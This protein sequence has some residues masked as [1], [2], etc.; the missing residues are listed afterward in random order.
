MWRALRSKNK[1]KFLDG[2]IPKSVENQPLFEAWDRCNN[3]LLSWL[4]LSLSPEIAKSVMW[5]SNASDM[6]ND[7]KN[8]YSQGDVFRVGELKEEF[9][10]I[11]QGDL[12]ITSYF[13]KLKSVWE[14]LENLHTIPSCIAC[15][16]GYNCGLKIIRDYA[17]EEYVV[18]FLRGLN[19][20]YSTVKYQIMLLKPLPDINAVLAMLTQ[21]ERELSSDFLDT[22]IITN[23]IE[24]QH[25]QRNSYSSRGRGRGRSGGEE[26]TA[27]KTFGKGYTSK[28]CTYCNKIGHLVENC[29]KK[30]GFSAHW[31]Q[32]SAN[33]IST[34]GEIEDSGA[35][36][37]ITDSG[38]EEGGN[39]IALVLTLDQKKTLIALLQQPLMTISSSELPSLK[40]IGQAEMQGDL[41]VINAEPMKLPS[42]DFKIQSIA[43]NVLSSAF[44]N[45]IT[46]YETLFHSKPN[47]N[48]L[49]V[50]GCLVFASTLTAGRTKLDLRARKSVKTTTKTHANSNSH[51]QHSFSPTNF[52]HFPELQLSS[53]SHY[54]DIIHTSSHPRITTDVSNNN[55]SL[56]FLNN[57]IS[58]NSTSYASAS[59]IHENSDNATVLMP[60]VDHIQPEPTQPV[61]RRS[62]RD[63]KLPSYL[64]GFHCFSMAS[65]EDP[66]NAVHSSSNYKYPLSH[67]LSYASF[68]PK[69]LTF[70]FALIN[71]PGPKHYSEAVMHDC[72]R[73]AIDAEL[74][75]LEQNKTWIVTS[76]PPG[77]NAVGCKWIFRTKFNLDRTIERHKARL[78]AQG[79]T[80]IPG[81][82]YIDTFSPVV[83]M[84]TVRVLLAIAALKNLHLHQLD[85]N[86]AFLHRDLHEDVYMKLPKRLK[87]DNPKLVCKL[88]RSLYGLKQVSRQWNIKLSNALIDLGYIRSK[89]D[90]SLFT[91]STN[92]SFTAILVYVDDLVLAGDDLSK[93]EAVKRFL[94]SKFKIKDLGILKFLAW[95]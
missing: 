11:R 68:S 26:N 51:P 71:N 4:N 18:K 25:Q 33:H 62:K 39:E 36:G 63:R 42:L 83:K 59:Y 93:I 84:S 43:L 17:S 21:Q 69:H 47:L 64:K 87:C 80:Q 58:E 56:S 19:E 66:I 76:L 70:T 91:K 8:R 41:Y 61:L 92:V 75:V 77:K 57:D 85:V 73:K 14:E 94:D 2:S 45:N 27:P 48:E 20:Q 1:V 81:I 67:H 74:A 3:I 65:H 29:Y 13:T 82:D 10:T 72:W 37:D 52:D 15:V 7:L 49:K 34:E 55:S 24:V 30:N 44:L 46:L 23:S 12:T 28:L 79:F 6:W 53:A 31:K 35:G 86:T 89:N 78:V 5:I 95:K 9:Y 16:N 22:K 40:I 32:K 90:Y 88:E 54:E 38:Q 50:F 60:H